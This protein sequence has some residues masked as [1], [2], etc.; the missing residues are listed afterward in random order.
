L[1]P[2]TRA[3]VTL[4]ELGLTAATGK[5]IVG[6]PEGFYRKGN[7]EIVCQR[8]GIP[9]LGSFEAFVE[10]VRSRIGERRRLPTVDERERR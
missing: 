5:V 2:A 8:A 10:A 3:P 1:D 4:L 9:V 7:V 6:C